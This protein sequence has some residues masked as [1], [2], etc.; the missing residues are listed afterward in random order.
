MG[1][2]HSEPRHWA[3]LPEAKAR[4]EW[5]ECRVCR[6]KVCARRFLASGAVTLSYFSTV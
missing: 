3:I 6:E 1:V 2:R 5:W 4:R